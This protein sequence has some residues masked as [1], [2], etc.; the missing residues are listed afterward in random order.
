MSESIWAVTYKDDTRFEQEQDGIHRKLS[1]V[2]WSQ[3]KIFHWGPLAFEWSE[4]YSDVTHGYKT[5]KSIPPK[6]EEIVQRW[7]WL[8]IKQ[9]GVQQ[10]YRLTPQAVVVSA[11]R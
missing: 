6:G 9:K 10:W 4:D 5:Q 11:Q 1:D 7:H 2:D 3:V 8:G